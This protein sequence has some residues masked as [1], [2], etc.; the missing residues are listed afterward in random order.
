[1]VNVLGSEIGERER[2]RERITRASPFPF[3]CAAAREDARSPDAETAL[4][5]RMGGERPREPAEQEQSSI[6]F[7]VRIRR[8]K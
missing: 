1:M 8:P 3:S 5:C 4:D 7:V 2:R 6:V